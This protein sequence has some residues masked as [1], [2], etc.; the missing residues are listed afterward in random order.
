MPIFLP[1]S[2]RKYL[3]KAR[4]IQGITDTDS[5]IEDT[6]TPAFE[7]TGSLVSNRVFIRQSPYSEVFYQHTHIRL[8]IDS[9]AMIRTSTVT[10]LNEKISP[11][12]QSAHQANGWSLLKVLG[13]TTLHFSSDSHFFLKR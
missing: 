9:G 4:Q 2:D 8:T 12:N 10:G 1:E 13:E 7:I 5:D 3:A 6:E 11:T